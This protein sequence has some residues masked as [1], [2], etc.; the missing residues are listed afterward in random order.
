[1]EMII[2]FPGGARVDAH[3]DQYTVFPPATNNDHRMI[4]DNNPPVNQIT[5]SSRPG[6]LRLLACRLEPGRT[7]TLPIHDIHP[8][9]SS[10]FFRYHRDS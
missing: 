1:M 7:E 8:V 2:D 4:C 5:S 9:D 6:N 10:F 3:F